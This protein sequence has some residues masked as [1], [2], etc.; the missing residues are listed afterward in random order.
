MGGRIGTDNELPKRGA[1]FGGGGVLMG[2]GRLCEQ[3]LKV[4]RYDLP[5]DGE[6]SGGGLGRGG[7]G[8]KECMKRL[9]HQGSQRRGD[10]KMMITVS[11]FKKTTINRR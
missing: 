10:I 4:G 11:S 5:G 8:G 1:C 3:S 7:R 9:S 6:A 2:G